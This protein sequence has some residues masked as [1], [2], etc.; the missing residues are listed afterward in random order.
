MHSTY[1]TP[2]L[3]PQGS[4][5][6]EVIELELLAG[7]LNPDIRTIIIE[8][9]SGGGGLGGSISFMDFLVRRGVGPSPTSDLPRGI[10]NPSSQLYIPL[11]V[12]IHAGICENAFAPY[13]EI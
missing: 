4:I 3:L 1:N 8:Q 6:M 12:A 2:T 13:V 7:G 10:M 9:L 5:Q 11:F